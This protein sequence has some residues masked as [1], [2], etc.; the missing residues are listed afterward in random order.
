MSAVVRRGIDKLWR[1][2]CTSEH[3]G[4]YSCS[5]AYRERFD[6]Q[7]AADAHNAEHHAEDER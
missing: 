6:A 7:V 3:C 4:G 5:V 2:I 1:A